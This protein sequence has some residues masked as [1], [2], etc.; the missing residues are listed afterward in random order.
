MP[1]KFNFTIFGGLDKQFYLRFRTLR[2]KYKLDDRGMIECMLWL[3]LVVHDKGE[4]VI[5]TEDFEYLVGVY[6]TTAPVD[7]T[8]P[9]VV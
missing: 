5:T 8:L 2:E 4:S 3:A 9:E 1:G 7:I 6:K